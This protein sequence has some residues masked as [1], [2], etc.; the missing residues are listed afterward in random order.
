MVEAAHAGS[1]VIALV[2]VAT[3]T[4]HWKELVF[5][6]AQAICFLA[7]PRVKFYIGGVEDPKGAPMSCAVIYYGQHWEKFAAAFNQH[8]A[9]IP[10]VNAVL[11]ADTPA[12]LFQLL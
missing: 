9:V 7:T 3:N 4:R 5:P 12:D 10:L 1:E 8:G 11:P 6:E 2:P